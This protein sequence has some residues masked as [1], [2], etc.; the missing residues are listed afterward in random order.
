M[1]YKQP[2]TPNDLDEIADQIGYLSTM[3]HGAATALRSQD[4]EELQLKTGTLKGVVLKRLGE[5]CEKLVLEIASQLS[6]SQKNSGRGLRFI[7]T[8]SGAASQD[9]LAANKRSNRKKKS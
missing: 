8:M 7:A 1:K 3:L 4:V 9:N 5:S 6:T 2:T